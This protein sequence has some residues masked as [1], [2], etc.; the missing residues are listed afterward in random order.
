MVDILGDFMMRR[1]KNLLGLEDMDEFM[2]LRISIE[3]ESK[4]F[5]G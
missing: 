3:D 5:A 4:A 1:D 2:A